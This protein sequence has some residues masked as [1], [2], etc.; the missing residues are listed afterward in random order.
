LRQWLFERARPMDDR[1]WRLSSPAAEKQGLSEAL[2]SLSEHYAEAARQPDTAVIGSRMGFPG[3]S[4][5]TPFFLYYRNQPARA[6]GSTSSGPLF[7][8]LLTLMLTS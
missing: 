1:A 7:C 2:T 5:G 6:L 8:G 4:Q 3:A